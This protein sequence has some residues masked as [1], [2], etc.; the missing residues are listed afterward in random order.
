MTEQEIKDRLTKT[1]P[2]RQVTRATIKAAIAEGADTL[3]KIKAKTGAMTG[4][5][6]GTRCTESIRGL[7][8]QYAESNE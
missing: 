3:D 5:C 8:E 7:L 4:C 6:H 1:C 2:C